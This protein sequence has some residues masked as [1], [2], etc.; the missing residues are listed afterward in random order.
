MGKG[1][2]VSISF[3]L[4]CFVLRRIN[5]QTVMD[6]K[7][8][9][10]LTFIIK[11]SLERPYYCSRLV[12]THWIMSLEASNYSLLSVLWWQSFTFFP[13]FRFYWVDHQHI[14]CVCLLLSLICILLQAIFFYF[15]LKTFIIPPMVL[16]LLGSNLVNKSPF[17]YNLCLWMDQGGGVI[18]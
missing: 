11:R 4:F 18:I 5:M 14:R 15:I 16:V 1:K 8:D 10:Q 12:Q 17:H 7:R 2:S 9:E 13:D 3:S 6:M